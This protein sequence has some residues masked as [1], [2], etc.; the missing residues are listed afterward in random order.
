MEIHSLENQ[1]DAAEGLDV[2]QCEANTYKSYQR[3]TS[4]LQVLQ[5]GRKRV[6]ALVAA[7]E[8]KSKEIGWPER[9]EA[10]AKLHEPSKRKRS[11]GVLGILNGGPLKVLELGAGTGVC[12][13]FLR[14][15][16]IEVKSLMKGADE[17]REEEEEEEETKEKEEEG[18]EMHLA[19]ERTGALYA[20]ELNV[21]LQRDPG[22]SVHRWLPDDSLTPH[23]RDWAPS[24]RGEGDEG[25]NFKPRAHTY[26]IIMRCLSTIPTADEKA[27]FWRTVD[28]ELSKERRGFCL[29]ACDLP[30]SVEMQEDGVLRSLGKKTSTIEGF[31]AGAKEFNFQVSYPGIPEGLGDSGILLLFRRK[32]DGDK[33]VADIIDVTS[34]PK[35]YRDELSLP[36]G[37]ATVFAQ[38]PPISRRVLIH[39]ESL[40]VSL[41]CLSP[42]PDAN[43][44]PNFLG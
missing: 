29:V 30:P 5:K 12:G 42:N 41:S 8:P 25:L 16:L 10:G 18:F 21:A 7:L 15:G 33:T 28:R 2:G 43:P 23:K 44:S 40:Q 13:L 9:E 35:D 37:F 4:Q 1:I 11:P 22:I 31:I 36:D 27:R 19:E 6:E 39:R 14:M 17:E 3:W 20:L 32:I 34:K 26:H 24:V 38:L